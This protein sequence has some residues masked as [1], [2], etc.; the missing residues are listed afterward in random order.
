MEYDEAAMMK[1]IEESDL[2]SKQTMEKIKPVFEKWL[3][4]RFHLIFIRM[5]MS[6][7]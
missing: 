2:R 5:S 7:F 1:L 6:L 4:Y 3:I